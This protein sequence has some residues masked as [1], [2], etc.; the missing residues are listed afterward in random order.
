MTRDLAIGIDIGGTK[1]AGGVVDLATGEV[2]ARHRLPTDKDRGGETVLA[3][4]RECI[5]ALDTPAGSLPVGVGVPELVDRYGVVRSA[6]NFEWRGLDLPKLLAPARLTCIESDVRAA[7]IAELHFGHGRQ[8]PSFAYITLGTGLSYTFCV[9]G[10]VHRGARGFAIHFASADLQPVCVHCG[11]QGPFNLE[12]FAS[13]GG[14]RA[15]DAKRT[16]GLGRDA[17]ALIAATDDP[18]ATELVDQ[19]TTALAAALAQL[20]DMLDPHALV[21]GGGLSGSEAF[22]GAI[23][24]KLPVFIW[25]ESARDLPVLVSALGADTGVIGAAAATQDKRA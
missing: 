2:L 13:G 21:L 1:I 20:V 24:R 23:R 18:G 17:H 3:R 11:R 8:Q 22:V 15:Q 14:M 16:C 12:G 5:A 25:A 4:V 19:A 6:W 10:R 9:D 7:A